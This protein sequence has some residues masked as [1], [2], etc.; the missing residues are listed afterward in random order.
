MYIHVCASV[1]KLCVCAVCLTCVLLQSILSYIGK[2]ADTE[3]PCYSE[4]YLLVTVNGDGLRTMVIPM[5]D[6]VAN[7][8]W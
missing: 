6:K 2:V 8:T 7:Y 3:M 5:K 1:C 4:N